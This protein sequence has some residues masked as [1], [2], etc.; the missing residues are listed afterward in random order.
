MEVSNFCSHSSP[1]HYVTYSTPIVSVAPNR[2]LFCCQ[3]RSIK[4]IWRGGRYR[5]QFITLTAFLKQIYNRFEFL[6]RGG[7]YTSFCV[8]TV[9]NRWKTRGSLGTTG[10]DV[11]CCVES[12]R[13]SIAVA[14]LIPSLTH[15]LL[16]RKYFC[17]IC[18][19]SFSRVGWPFRSPRGHIIRPNKIGKKSLKGTL[20]MFVICFF[21]ARTMLSPGHFPNSESHT[22][23]TIA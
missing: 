18:V 20:A 21:I 10:P 8:V 2:D 4:S 7:V 17:Y 1:L 13:Q 14:F 6:T 15:C 19:C 12:C 11:L 22:L 16:S 23:L 9:Q 3:C 5:L